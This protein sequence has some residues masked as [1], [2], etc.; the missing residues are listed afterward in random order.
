MKRWLANAS[1]LSRV[2]GLPLSQDLPMATAEHIHLDSAEHRA[3][4]RSLRGLD[5]LNFFLAGVST[6]LGP[7]VARYLAGR[8]WTQVEIGFVLTVSGLT[9]LLIQVPAG[10][11]LD[12][13][14]SKRPLI[15]IGVVT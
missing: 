14:A 15:A 6:G 7:V 11:L 1:L 8:A 4:Q 5:W 12:M 10:E 13:A 3:S 9:G 2:H